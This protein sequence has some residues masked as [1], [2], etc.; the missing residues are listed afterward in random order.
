MLLP[1]CYYP[2]LQAPPGHCPPR[3]L[4]HLLAYP[5]RR[6]QPLQRPPPWPPLHP[7]PPLQAPPSPHLPH[8]PPALLPSLPLAP[9]PLSAPPGYLPALPG[10]AGPQSLGALCCWRRHPPCGSA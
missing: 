3:L 6:C 9:G 2:P 1:L 8:R 4:P 5:L 10:P 7:P